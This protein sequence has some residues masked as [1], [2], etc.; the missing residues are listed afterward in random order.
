MSVANTNEGHALAEAALQQLPCGVVIAAKERVYLGNAQALALWGHTE[1]SLVARPGLPSLFIPEQAVQVLEAY[2]AVVSAGARVAPLELL[3]ARADGTAVEVEVRLSALRHRGARAALMVVY[4]ASDRL[5]STRSLVSLAYQDVITGLPNR[6]HFLDAVVQALHRGKRQGDGFA[7]GM[8]DLD[9]FKAVNDSAGHDAGDTVLR[10]VAERLRGAVRESDV[11]ARLGGDE[12]TVLL[13]GVLDAA[14]AVKAAHA[15]HHA[16][17]RPFTVAG[18]DYLLGVSVGLAVF[19]QHGQD[20]QSLLM[21][22]DAAMYEGKR[23]GK[24]VTVVAD[25]QPRA[26][27]HQ[28]SIYLDWLPGF[29]TGIAPMDAEHRE[30]VGR[31]N[32]LLGVLASAED[33]QVVRAHLREVTD[34]ARIHFAAEESAMSAIQYEGRLEH[35]HEHQGL[36]RELARIGESFEDQGL[37]QTMQVVRD[38]LLVHLRHADRLF[39][40]ALDG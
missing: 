35:A 13:P 5:R 11:L 36:L 38:W 37:S 39:A 31:V 34:Y 21:A 32:K 22:A 2:D 18:H 25:G 14:G 28:P 7:V 6:A 1:A 27:G 9:G 19:P 40:R 24:G 26:T 4:D 33:P 8:L 3:A 20:L 30:L 10:E 29:D 15:M 12:F 16:L 23:S 17:A